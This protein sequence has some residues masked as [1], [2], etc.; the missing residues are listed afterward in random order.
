M[1]ERGESSWKKK[2]KGFKFSHV[3]LPLGGDDRVPRGEW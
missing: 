2:A 3:V 1:G